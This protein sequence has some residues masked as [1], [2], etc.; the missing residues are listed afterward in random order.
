MNSVINF[1]YILALEL[2]R[3]RDRETLTDLI[4]TVDKSVQVNTKANVHYRSKL[5][6]EN[7]RG[8]AGITQL[9]KKTFDTGKSTTKNLHNQAIRPG[10][11]TSTKA[12]H[13]SRKSLSRP[14]FDRRTTTISGG[15]RTPTLEMK[16][17]NIGRI[18]RKKNRKNFFK[19]FRDTNSKNPI[20]P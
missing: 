16:I 1:L 8:E 7:T 14:R 12:T 11:L 20:N 3:T 13:R 10:S 19:R 15:D 6:G 2:P 17:K 9:K 4:L 18:R 5:S